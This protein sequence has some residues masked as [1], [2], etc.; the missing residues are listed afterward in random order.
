MT[1]LLAAIYKI[2]PEVPLAWTDVILG[3]G[4]TSFL[5][6]L[7]KQPLAFYLGK[8]SIGSTY[9]AAGSLVVVLVWVY[10]SA[11]LFFLG[12]EFNKVYTRRLGSLKH[13]RF[14]EATGIQ[15]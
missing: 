12:A 11:Q 15:L 7:G 9:G 2:L 4:L 14:V 6:T 10:Y 3:A 13:R 1:V 5:I 8:V